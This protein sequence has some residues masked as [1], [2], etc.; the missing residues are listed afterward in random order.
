ME[1]KP[2][3]ISYVILIIICL[4]WAIPLLWAFMTAFRPGAMATSFDFSFIFT[5]DNYKMVFATAPFLK[6]A[7]NSIIIVL[8]ILLV[9]FITITTGAYALA[10]VDFIGKGIFMA[11]IMTQLIVP[12]DVLILQNYLTIKQFHLVDTLPGVMVPYFASAMGLLLLRQS[13]KS[14]PIALEEAAKIDGCNILQILRYVYM[15]SS[16]TAYISFAIISISAHW[17]NFLWPVIVIN[18]VDKRPLTVGLSLIAKASD[19]GPQWALLAAATLMVMMP[20]FIMFLIF[21][22]QFINS[23]ISSGVK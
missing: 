7:V 12:T 23:F 6:Y 2:G 3:I 14:I 18:S 1:K 8:G 19:A 16:K 20:L 5:F 21:Q 17:N 10:R 11:L 15:P 22:K 4:L 9:Q 13:F